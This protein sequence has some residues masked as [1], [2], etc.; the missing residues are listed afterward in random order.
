[1]QRVTPNCTIWRGIA[2]KKWASI[3]FSR[4]SKFASGFNPLQPKPL[5]SIVD[6]QRLKDRYP[7]DIASIWDD[8]ILC[9]SFVEGKWIH[10]NVCSRDDRMW[11]D[12]ILSCKLV[13][14]VLVV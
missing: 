1:M 4:T 3:G 10:Y 12:W 14:R 13:A 9:D 2:S 8:P 11:N 5:D 6:I 7:E